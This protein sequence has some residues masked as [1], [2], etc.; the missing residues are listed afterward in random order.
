MHIE[1]PPIDV[2]DRNVR[3]NRGKRPTNFARSQ[4]T[5][6]RGSR[7]LAEA[8][9]SEVIKYLYLYLCICIGIEIAIDIWL[10]MKI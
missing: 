6:R 8:R 5:R 2:S 1:M 3:W 7:R 10:K 9:S 4:P